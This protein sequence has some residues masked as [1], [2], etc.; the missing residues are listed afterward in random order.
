MTELKKFSNDNK[1]SFVAI[2]LCLRRIG[3]L[4][5]LI[6]II[7]LKY[8]NNVYQINSLVMYAYALNIIMHPNHRLQYTN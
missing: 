2:I 7:I 5:E 8:A 6:E 1:N 4:K 3:L